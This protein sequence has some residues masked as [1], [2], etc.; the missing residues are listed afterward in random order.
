MGVE[1][2][3][4]RRKVRLTL[5]APG[6][7][8]R[9]LTSSSLGTAGTYEETLTLT[10]RSGATRDFRLTGSFSLRRISPIANLTTQ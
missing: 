2:Y 6:T 3:G 1:S 5:S 8:F 9:S 4:I 7:D 10:G